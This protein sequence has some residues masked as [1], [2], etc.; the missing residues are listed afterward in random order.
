MFKHSTKY[1]AGSQEQNSQVCKVM[2][3]PRSKVLSMGLSYWNDGPSSPSDLKNFVFALSACLWQGHKIIPNLQKDLNKI[4]E[5][6]IER[7]VV[8]CKYDKDPFKFLNG[9]HLKA[10]IAEIVKE[11]VFR[12]TERKKRQYDNQL[13]LIHRNV[14]D[15][16]PNC[17]TE[18]VKQKKTRHKQQSGN[19]KKS[20]TRKEQVF[21]FAVQLFEK[22][23]TI[24]SLK[25]LQAFCSCGQKLA[26]QARDFLVE[27]FMTN[28]A[29]LKQG[30][31]YRAVVI[32]IE[33]KYKSISDQIRKRTTILKESIS[34]HLY[35]T[36][37]STP[38]AR[39]QCSLQESNTFHIDKK[40]KELPVRDSG[41][42]SQS[43][44]TDDQLFSKEELELMKKTQ[45]PKVHVSDENF[46]EAELYKKDLLKG[47]LSLEQVFK[48]TPDAC[49]KMC[50]TCYTDHYQIHNYMHHLAEKHFVG[51]PLNN[52][53]TP[54][55]ENEYVRHRSKIS[56][57]WKRGMFTNFRFTSAAK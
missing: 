52:K 24:P 31:Q 56:Y 15:P 42:K 2:C 27:K 46:E 32:E 44:W 10:E 57:L 40:V 16:D 21:H 25:K 17:I 18:I 41:C 6:I 49:I 29:E 30:L 4:A 1:F 22:L 19:R 38:N 7:L 45:I 43:K 9:G 50:P 5:A 36:Q 14:Y 48:N 26:Q 54:T 20:K 11:Q 13:R 8:L 33:D 55:F 53:N 39:K 12:K 34:R 47:A 51:S 23:K 28:V 3:L 37:N 35:L